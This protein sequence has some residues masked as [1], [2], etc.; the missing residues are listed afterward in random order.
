MILL[1]HP[2][3]IPEGIKVSRQQ[4]LLTPHVY[5]GTIHNSQAMESAWVSHQQMNGYRQ[6]CTPHVHHRVLFSH[7]EE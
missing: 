5:C 3:Y 2:G 4:R 1:Y 6:M 7:K